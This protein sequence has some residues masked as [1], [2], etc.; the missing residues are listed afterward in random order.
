[1]NS[2]A[3]SAKHCSIISSILLEARVLESFTSKSGTEI[4]QSD[5]IA[6]PDLC[7]RAVAGIIIM[8]LKAKH[9]TPSP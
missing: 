4:L 6:A 1:M 7:R 3:E 8:V 9:L 2:G 5:Y